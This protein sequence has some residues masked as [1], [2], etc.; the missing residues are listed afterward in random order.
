M[1]H[2]KP[3][4]TEFIKN[5]LVIIPTRLSSSRLPGKPLADIC[6]VPMIVRVLRQA[7]S[8]KC[9][10]VIVACCDIEVKNVVEKAGGVAIM[11]NPNHLSGSDRIYEALQILDPKEFYDAVLNIQGDL[12][13]ISPAIPKEALTLLNNEDVDIGTLATNIV[14]TSELNDPNVVKAIVSLNKNKNNGKA[15]Y[16]TRANAPF[17]DGESWHHIGIYAYRRKALQRFVSLTPSYLEQREKLEQ[18]RALEDGMRIE[19]AFVDSVPLGV[20]TPADLEKVRQIV[21]NQTKT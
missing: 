16:F 4:N 12:P 13:T 1:S 8:A 2:K 21:D 5:P 11:T 6:G 9:G 7:E 17:G 10:P 18:L 19:V 15:I 3:Q 20:D 14:E